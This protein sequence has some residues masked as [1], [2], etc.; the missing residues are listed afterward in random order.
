MPMCRR[1]EKGGGVQHRSIIKLRQY[2]ICPEALSMH[3]HDGV[4]AEAMEH[5]GDAHCNCS[6]MGVGNPG[7]LLQW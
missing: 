5:I 2:V 7:R 4:D 6:S 3:V 1:G